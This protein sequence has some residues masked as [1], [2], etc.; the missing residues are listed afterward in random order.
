MWE[1]TFNE[2]DRFEDAN[3][4]EKAVAQK[5]I[6]VGSLFAALATLLF[7]GLYAIRGPLDLAWPNL[8]ASGVFVLIAVIRTRDVT[9]P[10]YSVITAALLLFGYEL[11]LLGSINNGISVFFLAPNVAAM[12]LGMRNLAKYCGTITV[13]EIVGVSV[14][15]YVGRFPAGRVLLPEPELVMAASMIA[16]LILCS[17]FALIAQ[18]ARERLTN[19]LTAR[20][21]ELANALEET[22]IARNA[23]LEASLAKERFFANLTHEIRTPLNGIAGTAEL[24]ERTVLSPDQQHLAKALWVST[25]NLVDL[26]NTILDHAKITA[27]HAKIEHGTL[28]LH[29]LAHELVGMF[30]ARAV[31]KNISLD[32]VVAEGSPDWIETDGVKV[33]QIVGNL[34]SNAIKFTTSGFVKVRFC[35]IGAADPHKGM[36]LIVEVTDTGTGIPPERLAAVFEPFVQGDASITRLHG[37]TGLGLSIARQ[38]AELLGGTLRAESVP[39][40]GS[41]FTFEVPVVPANA[42]QHVSDRQVPQ[43]LSLAGLRVLLVEDNPVNQLV[44]KAMLEA[45]VA[46]VDLAN[47]GLEAVEMVST[48]TYHIVLM[49]LQMPLMDGIAA[50]REIRFREQLSDRQPVP[51][52]AMTGNSPDDY[53]E[54]CRQ[55][56]MDGFLMKPVTL[57]QLTDVLTRLD[58]SFAPP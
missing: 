14:G 30:G 39:G 54:A 51:I 8:V 58:L 27:G 37:G 33:R 47:N 45:V 22:D 25:R 10:L 57:G 2:V 26:V 49:D 50:T 17:L 3:L 24:L 6:R 56:G 29:Q 18:R 4:I 42:P 23:A 53:G 52:I 20:N 38:L 9:I 11:A 32:V 7:A 35:C 12:I 55:S 5:T 43:T 36:R 46:E 16:V 21:R 13:I 34:L 28:R 19:E 15:S 44:A 31:E 40:E 41:T 48:G 1:S